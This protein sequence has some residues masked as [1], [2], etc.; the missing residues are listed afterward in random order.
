MKQN[1]GDEEAIRRYLL[2]E[3]L[4]EEQ[5]QVESRLLAEDDYYQRLLLI[6]GELVEDYADE[7]LSAQERALAEKHFFAAPERQHELRFTRALK[8]Y[9]ES[10]TVAAPVAAPSPLRDD[11]PA[12]DW[13]ESLAAFFGFHGKGVRVALAFVLLLAVVGASSLVVKS[14]RLRSQL[15][16]ARAQEAKAM[17]QGQQLER[18][19]ALERER[20]Q[21]LADDLTRQQGQRENLE[22]ELANLKDRAA[23]K[24]ETAST[25]RPPISLAS[26]VQLSLLPGLTRDAGGMQKLSIRAG[27]TEVRV[28]LSLPADDYNSY[29]AM[30]RTAEGQELLTRDGLKAR[31]ARRSRIVSFSI[32]AK[33][34]KRGDYQFKLSGIAAGEDSVEVNTYTFRVAQE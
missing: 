7:T 17:A 33:L 21:Q 6:E 32:P 31:T 25:L 4:P 18:E 19:I 23:Q 8:R 11:R 30:L 10:A 27:V 14:W 34:L 1:I 24:P 28:R 12:T 13:K 22:Q 3:L 5:Q 26:F 9:V 29:R 20:N 15:E 2:G 16:E